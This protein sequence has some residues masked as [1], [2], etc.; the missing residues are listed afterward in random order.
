MPSVQEHFDQADE[1][2][3]F[4]DS[5]FS[6]HDQPRWRVIVLFYIAVHFMDAYLSQYAA[7]HPGNHGQRFKRLDDLYR[8]RRLDGRIRAAYRTLY[9]SSR[10]ARYNCTVITKDTAD[11]LQS[12]QLPRIEEYVRKKVTPGRF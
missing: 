5:A 4:L 9:N 1:N 11:K 7:F 8:G 12:D 3:A 6:N 2:I 10:E